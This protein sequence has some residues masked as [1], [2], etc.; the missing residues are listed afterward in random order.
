MSTLKHHHIRFKEVPDYGGVEEWESE[1]KGINGVTWVGIDVDKNDIYVEYELEKCCEEA[2]EHWMVKSGFVLDDSFLQKLKRGMIH[3][4]EE[5]AR[6]NLS[7]KP[8]SCHD[9]EDIKRKRE[10]PK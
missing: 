8:H 4:T 10:E 2:I 7:T 3:F 5:N 1:L 9:V 6:E